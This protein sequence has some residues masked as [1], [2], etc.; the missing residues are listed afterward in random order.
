MS[1]RED[2]IRLQEQSHV[3][4]TAGALLEKL[5]TLRNTSDGQSRRR[6]VWELLQNAL[7]VARP[8]V[9]L[10]VQVA[11]FRGEAG[12]GAVVFTHNG[13]PF[14]FKDLVYL[15]GKAST[16]ERHGAGDETPESVGRFGTGFLTTHLLSERITVV[17][18]C[19]H[20]GQEPVSFHLPLDR[21]GTTRAE[22]AAGVAQAMTV[23]DGLDTAERLSS[24]SLPE[25]EFLYPLEGQGATVA[26]AG[27]DDLHTSVAYTLAFNER[28]GQ[29]S[30]APPDA[31]NGRGQTEYRVAARETLAPGLEQVT[32]RVK[33]FSSLDWPVERDQHLV[34][35]RGTRVSVAFP[36]HVS[37]A[38]VRMLPVDKQVPR[39]HCAFP[40]VGTERF[41]FPGVVNSIRFHPTEPRDGVWLNTSG[42]PQAEEN[43]SLVEEAR[44]LVDSLMAHAVEARWQ[45]LF[46][47]ADLGSAE[48]Y[49]WLDAKRYEEKIR[50]PLRTALSAAPLVETVS[51]ERAALGSATAPGVWL[52]AGP[53]SEAREEMWELAR[54]FIPGKLPR[55]EHTEEWHRVRWTGLPSLT[56]EALANSVASAGT[57]SG[58]GAKIGADDDGTAAWLTRFVGFLKEQ[59]AMNL[60]DRPGK[61]VLPDQTGRFR[62]KPDL[63]ADSEIPDALK[64]IAEAFGYDIRAELLDRRVDV[65]MGVRDVR[66]SAH[67]AGEVGRRVQVRLAEVPRSDE[68]RAAFKALLVWFHANREEAEQLFGDLYAGWHTL[69]SDDEVMEDMEKARQLDSIL[70]VLA[71]HG[72]DE[73]DLEAAL[74]ARHEPTSSPETEAQ[75]RNE[76][77]AYVAKLVRTMRMTTFDELAGFVNARPD[78]FQ[79][80]HQPS[81]QGF[82]RFLDLTRRAKDA[83]RAY[84]ERDGSG[85]D[86]SDWCEDADHPTVV[87]G[88]RRAGHDREL[89]LVVRPSDG[90]KVIL[91]YDLESTALEDRDG[92]LWV[93]DDTRG[94]RQVTLGKVFRALRET[95]NVNQIPV[96]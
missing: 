82:L 52:P 48:T 85:Y 58:W 35:A 68:T 81:L 86:C 18:A 79:A 24:G 67:L 89:Y 41:P 16:K 60:L 45:D 94:V 75:A 76:A 11:Q 8:G 30:A 91:Y 28:L 36:V 37:E 43:W 39:L 17:G 14:T 71:A 53:D 33:A 23:L 47:L 88:V 56:A 40:L 69:R 15:A 80:V 77:V 31:G 73:G 74:A 1:F 27:L 50:V 29:V 83:V 34:V 3:D 70:S 12:G 7:D 66:T 38:G 44:G 90:G 25:T 46:V 64:E 19:V 65:P 20:G 59:D 4:S 49:S 93:Q 55:A 32:V 62:P 10:D 2:R 96:A 78:L 51:G 6:W 57:L 22:M 63:F 87:H 54:V 72:V 21:S 26:R 13:R 61:G 92:E 9:P 5:E 84:L 95:L 42:K